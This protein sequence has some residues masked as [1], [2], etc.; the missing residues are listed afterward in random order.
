MG[1][2]DR[3]RQ[4]KPRFENEP[5]QPPADESP[6]ARMRRRLAPTSIPGSVHS[7][8]TFKAKLDH[9]AEVAARVDRVLNDFAQELTR[10][11]RPDQY[12]TTL[13]KILDRH[14]AS[15]EVTRGVLKACK[16]DLEDFYS[17]NGG[18]KTV[19]GSNGTFSVAPRLEAKKT[20][21]FAPE[22]FATRG[23]LDATG[24]LITLMDKWGEEWIRARATPSRPMTQ[25][26]PPTN[27]M[28]A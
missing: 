13:G 16:K 3:L 10:V 6:T 22:S 5:Q 9:T 7:S 12:L 27:E 17:A 15:P 25:P 14:Q 8:E 1:M 11:D 2:F 24:G 23:Q 4:S 19:L 28:H 21:R 26:V 18:A 20:I